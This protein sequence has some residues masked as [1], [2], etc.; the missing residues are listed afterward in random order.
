MID[1]INAASLDEMHVLWSL[2]LVL[3]TVTVSICLNIWPSNSEDLFSTDKIR[4]YTKLYMLSSSAI[5][6]PIVGKIFGPHH[7]QGKEEYS[8]N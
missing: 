1:N 7:R 2:L 8:R 6:T 3:V 5:V 4:Q